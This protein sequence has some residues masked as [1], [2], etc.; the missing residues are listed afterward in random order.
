[1]VVANLAGQIDNFIHIKDQHPRLYSH[2]KI[3]QYN[4]LLDEKEAVNAGIAMLRRCVEFLVDEIL[5]AAGVDQEIADRILHKYYGESE[6]VYYERKRGNLANNIVLL[7]YLELIDD[8]SYSAY[9]TIR[10]YGN[11]ATHGMV[12]DNYE[13][14]F[15][16]AEEVYALIYEESY[17]LERYIH[18]AKSNEAQMALERMLLASRIYN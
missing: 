11:D 14:I 6:R 4:L 18:Y 7:H 1:M 12:R 15:D 13:D 2:L 16:V 10:V 3:A 8:E 5:T 9:N 17:Q